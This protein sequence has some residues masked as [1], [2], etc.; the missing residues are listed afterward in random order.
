MC[1]RARLGAAASTTWPAALLLGRRSTGGCFIER[2]VAWQGARRPTGDGRS[3]AEYP[4]A[5]LVAAHPAARD[6]LHRNRRAPSAPPEASGR[7]PHSTAAAPQPPP[8][9][10]APAPPLPRRYEN[11]VA[12]PLLR[13]SGQPWARTVSAGRPAGVR[14]E[15]ECGVTQMPG[16]SPLRGR[17]EH[18]T[19]LSLGAP[20]PLTGL[21]TS[22][23]P[24]PEL[25][26]PPSP[27]PNRSER[28]LAQAGPAVCTPAGASGT[29][30]TSAPQCKDSTQLIG[31]DLQ[32]VFTPSLMP[33]CVK[34]CPDGYTG[35]WVATSEG[36]RWR[37]VF[38]CPGG[39]RTDTCAGCWD[40]AACTQQR[41]ARVLRT[42]G[43]GWGA[44]SAAG[45]PQ[46]ASMP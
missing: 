24:A 5:A 33:V 22:H 34:P 43:G 6:D 9:Y 44:H 7:L 39:T 28:A 46:G 27:S 31:Q 21:D 14:G 1:G 13:A 25:P 16:A 2:V 11:S 45:Q 26:T 29:P 10:P 32:P 17:K 36:S 35:A 23:Y 15:R 12:A 40:G 37:C 3:C 30:T 42:G 18:T 4:E 20:I 8:L 38:S 19:S 41:G